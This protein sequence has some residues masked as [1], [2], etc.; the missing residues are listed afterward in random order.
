[1]EPAH[2]SGTVDNLERTARIIEILTVVLILLVSPLSFV[3]M[4]PFG[5]SAQNWLSLWVTYVFFFVVIATL[6]GIIGFGAATSYRV[7]A[8]AMR[9]SASTRS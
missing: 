6:V 9:K 4:L 7:K 2:D 3:I 1:M 8:N 5:I